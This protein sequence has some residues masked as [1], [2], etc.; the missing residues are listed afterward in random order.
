MLLRLPPLLVLLSVLLACSPDPPPSDVPYDHTL[1]DSLAS[2]RADYAALRRPQALARA[3]RLRPLLHAA[4]VPCPIRYGP[5]V[6][7]T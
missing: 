1:V 2:L 6:T 4:G 7:S 3:R 5:R